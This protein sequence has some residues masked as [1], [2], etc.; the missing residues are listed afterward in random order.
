MNIPFASKDLIIRVI[1]WI[2]C[3][4]F[5]NYICPFI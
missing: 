1:F 3:K 2:S 4:W 5:W